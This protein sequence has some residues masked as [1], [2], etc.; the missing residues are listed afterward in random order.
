MDANTFMLTF[1]TLLS[2]HLVWYLTCLF[3]VVVCVYFLMRRHLF[4]V[5]DPLFFM[6]IVNETFCIADV[7][8]MFQFGM[9]DA[10]IAVNYLLTESAMFI[11]I[12][13]FGVIAR[14]MVFSPLPATGQ[15][16]L[17]LKVSYALS[18]V[19][20]VALHL[21]VYVERGIPILQKS[22]LVI[23]KSPGW[24]VLDRVFDVFLV[25]VIYY[26]MDVLRRRPWKFAEWSSILTLIAIEIL[27]GAKSSVMVLFGIAGLA[28]YFIGT[29][30]TYFSLR[31]N[32]FRIGILLA[33]AGAF[34]V[35]IIQ[36]NGVEQ[37]EQQL[38]PVDLLVFRLVS[39]GDALIYAY[40][41]QFIETLDSR[42][43]LGAVLKEF[44][45][46]F[47]IVPS[48]E[49]PE[50]IGVQIVEHLGGNGKETMTNAKHNL[51]G[52]VY[53]GFCGSILYSYLVGTSVG[54]VRYTLRRRLPRNWVG[55]VIFTMMSFGTIGMIVEPDFAPRYVIG[56][57]IIFI[58]FVFLASVLAT[59][60]RSSARASGG[61]GGGA[62]LE[63]VVRQ[64]KLARDLN[65][66]VLRQKL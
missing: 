23:Y 39:S 7:L 40:P 2:E 38:S 37:D 49:L 27:S 43:P 52:F 33:M 20:F 15:P 48:D 25:I 55:G 18:L 29:S 61:V 60:V 28:S 58:P 62:C 12:L 11:G 41:N 14:S 24:G 13:Q 6:L 32:Y 31:S 59:A 10:R 42:N 34:A 53:F 17:A 8:F 66:H 1:F 21:L 63:A 16:A 44:L 54:L 5:L 65:Y 57:L 36:R 50:H 22:R 30:K 3:I 4:S 35:I 64:V 19:L 47:R 45:T 56:I 51:F 9:I 26:L 46:T